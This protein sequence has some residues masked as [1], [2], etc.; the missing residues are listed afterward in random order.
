MKLR[1][2][3]GALVCALTFLMCDAGCRASNES[4]SEVFDGKS[5]IDVKITISDENLSDMREYA[6][7]EEFHTADVEIDGKKIENVG[8]RTKGNMT[9]NS[10]SR[11]DSD[12]YSYKIKFDKYVKKQTYLGLDELCL[13]NGYSDPSYMREFLHYEALSYLGVDV[14]E[15]S[16]CRVYIN[17]EL[18]GLYLAV[19]AIG[20]TYLEDAFGENYKN[21]QLY[22]MEKGSSLK[23]E[24]NEQYS[25][26][27]LKVG[28]DDEKA[29]LKKLIK[30]LNS[31]ADGEKGDIEDVLDVSSALKYIAANTVLCNYDSYNGNMQQNYFLYKNEDGKF[32]VIP[33][34]FNMS[35]GGFDGDN[36]EIGIDTPVSSGSISDYPL[37]EK[38]LSVDECKM[39]YYSYIE[40]L[41]EYLD[42]FEDRVS[43]IKKLIS[44]D[45]KNDPTA[46]YTYDEFEAATTY[47]SESE[48]RAESGNQTANDKQTESGN[49]TANDKQTQSDKQTDKQ[50]DTDKRGGHGFG[51]GGK[52]II[53]CVRS[54]VESIKKQ[55]SGE[56]SKTTENRGFGGRG[57]GGGPGG[58]R[59]P[60]QNTDGNAHDAS[61][62]G[63]MGQPLQNMDGNA[64][65]ASASGGMGQPPQDMDGNAQPPETGSAEQ[66]DQP[67]GNYPMDN[68]PT[69]NRPNDFGGMRSDK[70]FSAKPDKIRVN[71]NGNILSFENNP[72]IEDGRTL[73]PIRKILEALGLTVD[74]D[75]GKITVTDGNT[76]VVCSAGDNK[77]YVNGEEY[78]LDVPVKIDSDTA[79]VPVRFISECF[80]FNVSWTEKSQ[81]IEIIKK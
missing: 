79:F 33:W 51:G 20:D 12:R 46:F 39:E 73:V 47:N 62:S 6:A 77:A 28:T 42:G 69:G 58:F 70:N 15:T 18:Q 72:Y 76:T 9:L 31:I 55:L 54:R 23:Y 22:K 66:G 40:K 10:V 80:G 52:S 19:E 57:N 60:P 16:F 61:A 4:Y 68:R 26:A 17:G 25:Y 48:N 29:G 34:D 30:T 63:G 67:T 75:N 44:S 32:T 64:H 3:I 35:F 36:S 5:I 45:V 27:E 53:N 38:L 50:A 49:Q 13:N 59:Q 43:E 74:W 78:T 1:K 65:D 7:N 56:Q 2:R 37:I 41:L 8:I 71:V 14:P 81:L 11:S 21:G 24:E